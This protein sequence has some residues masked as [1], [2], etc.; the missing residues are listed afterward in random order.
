MEMKEYNGGSVFKSG[1]YY[2]IGIVANSEPVLFKN[3]SC[4]AHI[5]KFCYQHRIALIQTIFMNQDPKNI[6]QIPKKYL[7]IVEPYINND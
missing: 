6:N 3:F 7:K 1:D 4:L 2:N 5:E